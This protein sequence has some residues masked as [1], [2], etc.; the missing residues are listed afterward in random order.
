MVAALAV[1]FNRLHPRL[2]HMTTVCIIFSLHLICH[3]DFFGLLAYGRTWT[4]WGRGTMG[5]WYR[6]LAAVCVL[7]GIGP[8]RDRR[9]A[10]NEQALWVVLGCVGLLIA[11][12]FGYVRRHFGGPPQGVMI[13]KRQGGDC[14]GRKSR[15][16]T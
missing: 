14:G 1:A 2:L 4:K 5:G 6:P 11:L 8:V 16:R 12:W 10:P 7:G 13:Q 9:A 3:P 15:G